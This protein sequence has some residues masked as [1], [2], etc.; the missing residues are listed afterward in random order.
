MGLMLKGNESSQPAAASSCSAGYSRHYDG[1]GGS[2]ATY[3][4][5]GSYGRTTCYRNG[6]P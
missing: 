2:S 5:R 6:N 3:S 1:C 4:T